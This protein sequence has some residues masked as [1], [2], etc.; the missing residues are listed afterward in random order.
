MA[1]KDLL[2]LL[3]TTTFSTFPV[4]D[5]RGELSGFV[6]VPDVRG[7]LYE[8][9]LSDLVV[10]REIARPPPPSLTP[11]DD[12]ETA[13]KRLVATDVDILPVVSHENPR[14]LLGLLSRRD[15]LRAYGRAVARE[16]GHETLHGG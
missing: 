15:V 1:L 6:S 14:T 9:G 2:T 7:I 5:A 11:D 12:L 4:V 13:L 8:E 3:T 10:A 16:P